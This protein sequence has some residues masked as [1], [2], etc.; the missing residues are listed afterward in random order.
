M[1][2]AL[3]LEVLAEQVAVALPGGKYGAEDRG[4][5]CCQWPPRPPDMEEVERGECAAGCPLPPR[6]D[7]DL[8][9]GQ[10]LLDEALCIHGGVPLRFLNPAGGFTRHRT[11][12]TS[13]HCRSMPS[14]RHYIG[15]SD[16]A[17]S[18]FPR[19]LSANSRKSV[20]ASETEAAWPPIAP[21][22]EASLKIGLRA[23]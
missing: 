13:I 15:V 22:A 23:S 6:L 10:P 20:Y 7:A 1:I 5:G 12:A 11:S 14:L 8:L 2:F 16:V 19:I 3:G 4:A 18:M 9:D 21:S 17:L